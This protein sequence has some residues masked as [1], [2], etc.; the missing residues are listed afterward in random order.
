[1]PLLTNFVLQTD[2]GVASAAIEECCFARAAEGRQPRPCWCQRAAIGIANLER[3]ASPIGIAT[4][5]AGPAGPRSAPQ[6]LGWAGHD[7]VAIVGEV[8]LPPVDVVAHA[9]VLQ[10]NAPKGHEHRTTRSQ[11]PHNTRHPPPAAGTAPNAAQRQA[12]QPVLCCDG[13]GVVRCAATLRR[14]ALQCAPAG[15]RKGSG[16]WRS[17]RCRSS[18]SQGPSPSC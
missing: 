15:R 5:S 3:R 10:P 13:L 16:S 4:W 1:M 7:D 6:V 14:G 18:R 11:T 2:P 17:L 12:R 8:E 9:A